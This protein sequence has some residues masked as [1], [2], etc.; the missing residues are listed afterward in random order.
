MRNTQA[1]RWHSVAPKKLVSNEVTKYDPI[2]SKAVKVM[3]GKN[4]AGSNVQPKVQ[5]LVLSV[6]SNHASRN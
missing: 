4:R 2:Q 5:C 3:I 1:A 6:T